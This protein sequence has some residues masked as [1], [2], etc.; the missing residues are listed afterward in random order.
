MNFN[1][2]P[3]SFSFSID[4]LVRISGFIICSGVDIIVIASFRMTKIEKRA[5]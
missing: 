4:D 3:V 2:C 5:F 1:I